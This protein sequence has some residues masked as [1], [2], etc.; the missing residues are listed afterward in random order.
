MTTILDKAIKLA[1]RGRPWPNAWVRPQFVRPAAAAAC[2]GG[3]LL[4]APIWP[5]FVF[6]APM[7]V[8]A[9]RYYEL[10]RFERVRASRWLMLLVLV[11]TGGAVLWTFDHDFGGMLLPLQLAVDVAFAAAGTHLWLTQRRLRSSQLRRSLTYRGDE[12]F[13][14][15][16]VFGGMLAL[17]PIL[18]LIGFTT[19]LASWRHPAVLLWGCAGLGLLALQVHAHRWFP[20]LAI[21]W[22]VLQIWIE[23]RS[24]L[25]ADGEGGDEG[26]LSGG[27]LVVI[28]TLAAYLEFHPRVR[29][30]FLRGPADDTAPVPPSEPELDAVPAS[31]TT[32]RRA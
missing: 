12:D 15:I 6:A 27:T 23:A 32:R 30:T 21:L 10:A 24:S 5:M 28:A 11:C 17:L 2:I 19:S 4:L 18:F 20:R 16:W 1:T 13:E 25:Q 31:L 3:G 22:L 26:W 8:M 7:L 9:C 29:G 14:P